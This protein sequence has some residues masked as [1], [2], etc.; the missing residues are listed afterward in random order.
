MAVF[1][2]LYGLKISTNALCC[3]SPA[4]HTVCHSLTTASI[5]LHWRHKSLPSEHHIFHLPSSYRTSPALIDAARRRQSSVIALK[6][7]ESISTPQPRPKSEKPIARRSTSGNSKRSSRP[8]SEK[9]LK[10]TSLFFCILKQSKKKRS[11]NFWTL[12]SGCGR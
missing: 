2:I 12:L 10:N 9:T 3:L 1:W 5:P 11:I 7:P 6:A 8:V 4:R